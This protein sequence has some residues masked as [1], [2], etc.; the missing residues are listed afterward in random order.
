MANKNTQTAGDEYD[1][2][3]E[4]AKLVK[5]LEG[6]QEALTA[7][8]ARRASA[9]AKSKKLA[10]EN[11]RLTKEASDAGRRADELEAKLRSLQNKISSL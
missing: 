2:T 1:L 10:E 11:L 4:N 3:V 5:R 8:D 7:A 9:E 6:A